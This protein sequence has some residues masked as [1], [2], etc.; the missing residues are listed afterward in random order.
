VWVDASD[1]VMAP[2]VGRIADVNELPGWLES[3]I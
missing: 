2:A 3:R 1:S